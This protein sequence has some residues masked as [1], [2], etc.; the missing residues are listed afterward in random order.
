MTKKGINI[1]LS[2][3]Y[4]IDEDKLSVNICDVRYSNV[5]FVQVTPR[6]VAMDLLQ[7]PGIKDENGIQRINGT[8]VYMT[9]SSAQ[10]LVDVLS[11]LLQE[12]QASGELETLD[13]EK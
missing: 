5:S 12:A 13:V 7:M 3:L 9:H 1:N 10:A 8:R 2:E 6:D 4:K 11:K